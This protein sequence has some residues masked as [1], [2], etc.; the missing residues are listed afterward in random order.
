ML[1]QGLTLTS[2]SDKCGCPL[3]RV[4]LPLL[5]PSRFRINEQKRNR[6]NVHVSV[7]YLPISTLHIHVFTFYHQCVSLTH[8]RVCARENVHNFSLY[9]NIHVRTTDAE[10]KINKLCVRL[11][12]T[13]GFVYWSFDFHFSSYADRSGLCVARGI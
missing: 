11:Q 7:S 5:P 10:H 2:S 1:R 8:V 6:E 12:R 9:T 13:R 4:P 3:M